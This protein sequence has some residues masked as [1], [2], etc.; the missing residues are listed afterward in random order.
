MTGAIA[1]LD[2][3]EPD[4]GGWRR[5]GLWRREWHGPRA[6]SRRRGDTLVTYVHGVARRAEPVIWP[7]GQARPAGRVFDDP[8]TLRGD[9]TTCWALAT[10]RHVVVGGALEF[11]AGAPARFTVAADQSL[12]RSH[13]P[14]TLA[15]A[16]GAELVLAALDETFARALYDALCSTTWIGPGDARGGFTMRAAARYVEFLRG[17]GAPALDLL[18]SGSEGRVQADVRAALEA[19]GW[20][21]RTAVDHTADVL[22]LQARLHEWSAR[23]VGHVVPWWKLS[24][25][26]RAPATL[27]DPSTVPVAPPPDPEALLDWLASSARIDEWEYLRAVH[28][29]DDCHAG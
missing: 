13:D 3:G 21:L 17:P 12:A 15:L 1:V 8:R 25:D 14:F 19:L 22:E 28:L 4:P 7:E 6:W 27:V 16:A 5:A 29:A 20:R 9:D 10:H 26:G 11:S 2:E 24:A 23:P 18:F